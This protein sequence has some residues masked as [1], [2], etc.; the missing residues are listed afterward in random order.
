MTNI[1][2]IIEEI[3]VEWAYRVHDGMPNPTN[4][5]H[6][7]ELRES[8]EELNLPNNVIYEVIDNLIKEK[9]IVKNK[10]SGNTYVVKKHN[11]NTQDLIKKD[12]S[13]D[14][15]TKVEKG[16]DEEK[17]D[18][19]ST[20]NINQEDIDSIDGDTK[21]DGMNKKVKAPGND[22]STVNEIGV[23]YAMACMEES[24]DDVEG[25]LDKKLDKTKLGKRAN[26]KK[27]RQIIQ[28]AR[29]E[30]KRVDDHIKENG[31]D[32]K[33][34]KVSHVWGAKPSLDAT[35]NQ[36]EELKKQ[37]VTEVNGIKIDKYIKIVGDGGGGDDPTDT[38]IVMV[39]DSQKPP[40]VE[41]LH[42]SNKTTSADI[43]ANGSPNEEISQTSNEAKNQVESEEDKAAIDEADK[44]AKEKV[45]D[46]RK[47]QKE[48][49]GEQ[50]SKMSRQI[51]DDDIADRMMGRLENGKDGNP[52]GIS[53]AKGKYFGKMLGHPATKAWMEKN[54]VEPPLT[55]EQKREALKVYSKG[56]SDSNDPNYKLRDDDIRILA[57][58]YGNE[59]ITT[60]KD[61]EKPVYSEKEMKSF[62]EEQTN[63]LNENR[64]RL[65]EIQ[66]GLGDKVY[67]DRMLHRLH[68]PSPES[69]PNFQLNMGEYDAGDLMKDKDGNL[70]EKK[71]GKWYKDGESEPS[72]VDPKTLEKPKCAVVVDD[73]THN[74]CLGVKEG[75][76]ASDGFT[77]TYTEIK[78]EDGNYKAIVYDRNKNVVAIQTCRSKSGPGGSV[79]DTIAYGK[80][81][82]RCMAKHTIQNDR[83]G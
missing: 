33:T 4:P 60:G 59:K 54:G 30:K 76:K 45:K 62:Y 64:N 57:E 47:R 21:E 2:E 50:G 35:A 36:L 65:N 51:E 73:K 79:N 26:K 70:Y 80:D 12:A 72:D 67:T 19:T 3:L 56:I 6:I 27:R 71:D 11:P 55:P 78:G 49:I 10:D 24:P 44:I 40:K 5:Q 13:D 16:D 48:Y 39:D 1:S 81:Y 25:C 8:M 23:G 53:K 22:T 20:S 52:P 15:I 18:T 37:G 14:D 38:M 58:F 82:Q 46:A 17:D 9:D 29:A 75:E 61:P 41:I 42:T 77:V 83:C 28:S 68:I 31:M 43:Q 63:A 66:D 32:P 7:I 34:T 69:P 74:H